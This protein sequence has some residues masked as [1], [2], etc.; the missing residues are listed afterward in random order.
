[1]IQRPDDGTYQVVYNGM[2]LY[3][4]NMR[5]RATPPQCEQHCG[6]WPSH[7]CVAG[8]ND[9]LGPFLVGPNQ[10]SIFTNDAP[11]EL[12]RRLLGELGR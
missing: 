7:G 1:M 6:S 3:W 12:F 4:V 9:E 11:A 5:R 10:R 8:R 2:P